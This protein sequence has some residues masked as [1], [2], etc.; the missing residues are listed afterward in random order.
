[1]QSVLGHIY[2]ISRLPE[3]RNASAE[4]AEA[5]PTSTRILRCSV[6]AAGGAVASTAAAASAST[7]TASSDCWRPTEA[8][9]LQSVEFF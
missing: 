2:S 6:A 4:S 5:S 9:S 8:D 1:M 7:S 3:G